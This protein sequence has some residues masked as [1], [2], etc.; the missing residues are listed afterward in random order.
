MQAS[1]GVEEAE[2]IGQQ[3]GVPTSYILCPPPKV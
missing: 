3:W 1:V 2:V